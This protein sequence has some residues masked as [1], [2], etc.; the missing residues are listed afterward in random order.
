MADG[1]ITIDTRI[2]KKNIRKDLKTIRSE[3][4]AGMQETAKV[5]NVA[6]G[7]I[8]LGIT[9]ITTASWGFIK[10]ASQIEDAVAGF[11]P[12]LKS[13]EKAEQLVK[14]LNETAS[15]TPFVFK[16]ISDTATRLL[17]TM[18]GDLEK[19]VETFRML[20]DT[21]GGNSQKLATIT[22]GFTKAMMKGKVDLESLNMIAEAGVPIISEMA[23]ML[24]VST[25]ELY[26][27]ISAGEITSDQLTETFQTMTSEGGIFFN[28]MEIASKTFSGLVSTLKDNIG[29]WASAMGNEL[30]DSVKDTVTGLIE[31]VKSMETLTAFTDPLNKIIQS[32]NEWAF[33]SGNLKNVLL[34]FVSTV[35]KA[36]SSGLI[37]AF[38]GFVIVLKS[39]TVATAVLNSTMALN[40]YVAVT[41]AVIGLSTALIGLI[42]QQTG[43]IDKFKESREVARKLADGTAELEDKLLVVN[44]QYKENREETQKYIDMQNRATDARSIEKWKAKVAQL[45]AEGIQIEMLKG[46]IEYEIRLRDDLVKKREEEEKQRQE[47]IRLAEAEAEAERQKQLLLEQTAEIQESLNNLLLSD[48]EEVLDLSNDVL[49]ALQQQADAQKILDSQLRDGFITQDQYSSSLLQSYNSLADALYSL[50]ISSNEFGTEGEKALFR[51]LEIIKSSKM[52]EQAEETGEETGVAL[53]QGVNKGVEIAKKTLTETIEYISN[54]IGNVTSGSLGTAL[55]NTF[56]LISKLAEGGARLYSGDVAGGSMAIAEGLGTALN[57]ATSLSNQFFETINTLADFSTASILETLDETL[58]GITAFFSEGGDLYLISNM[59]NQGIAWVQD[60][61]DGLLEN[62]DDILTE[63]GNIFTNVSNM[64]SDNTEMFTAIGTLVADLLEVVLDNLP[65]FLGAGLS[66]IGAIATGLLEN[67]DGLISGLLNIVVY[68]VNFLSDNLSAITEAG[69]MIISTLAMALVDHIPEILGAVLAI[70]EALLIAIINNLPEIISVVVAMMPEIAMAI[71][72]SIPVILTA[73]VELRV[74]MAQAVVDMMLEMGSN[75]VESVPSVIASFG[76]FLENLFDGVVDSFKSFGEMLGE[77]I[78]EGIVEPLS[79]VGDAVSGGVSSVGSFLS[80]T[81][82][83]IGS[84]I[85]GIFGFATGSAYIEQDQLA[86][87]HKGER[88]IPKTF[89]DSI[90]SGETMML[91]T[92]AFSSIMAGLSSGINY[93]PSSVGNVGGGVIQLNATITS[94]VEIDG[95]EIARTSYE[96]IDQLAGVSFGS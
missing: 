7:G 95:R 15:T 48:G 3:I 51:V 55:Q 78:V 34:G 17:P 75:I 1:S 29:L 76:E 13:A 83:G 73:M 5:A 64:I 91:D 41:G 2:D 57:M 24:N 47:A 63:I 23:T 52:V 69:I 16:D 68:I 43:F 10:S 87:I 82:S 31:M 46:S 65:E 67:V 84:A 42:N 36:F 61:V 71:I 9:A 45:R 54:I 22:N 14:M 49:T 28:G 44:R 39:A 18:N 70:N 72:E 37:Q 96:Y 21:A 74:A 92:S 30:L 85:G 66:M 88:I 32:F 60:F 27:M 26:S 81:A 11:T 38:T 93:S 40:P 6:L 33:E 25:Q 20:G 4:T 58:S 53:V 94:P 80:S 19:T 90:M 86:Q 89:N 77:A 50:G 62:Q 56:A 79:S 59:F 12:L 35:E 8:A